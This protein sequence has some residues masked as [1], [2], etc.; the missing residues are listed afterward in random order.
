MQPTARRTRTEISTIASIVGRRPAGCALRRVGTALALLAQ[1]AFLSCG[2]GGGGAGPADP[3]PACG[4]APTFLSIGPVAP[5]GSGSAV[6]SIENGGEGALSET[7]EETC[8]DFT[9][10]P[11]SYEL[12]PGE[13]L[14]VS[15][16]FSP[17]A[18][19]DQ[20]C[21]ISP[22]A[23]C[24][25]VEVLGRVEVP[26]GPACALSTS[27]IDFGA[28]VVGASAEAGFQIRNAGSQPLDAVVAEGCGAFSLEAGG[29]PFSLA[30]DETREVR[31][32][33][34]PQA[35]GGD[36][37]TITLG[38][39]CEN[40]EAAG[41]GV[42]AGDLSGD[43]HFEISYTSSSCGEPVPIV[44]SIVIPDAEH[45]DDRVLR[46]TFCQSIGATDCGP[47]CSSPC[48]RRA[49]ALFDIVGDTFSGGGRDAEGSSDTCSVPFESDVVWQVS[50]AIQGRQISG[51]IAKS[52][53]LSTCRTPG[54][55]PF[56][57]Q[58]SGT[59]TGEIR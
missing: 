29:G 14:D 2:G 43:W 18:E 32:R 55:D 39:L 58:Y 22:G 15:V 8:P 37:C 17:A 36:S 13:S 48:Y 4:V 19:G 50:G 24:A 46:D 44:E 34:S 41:E 47:S 52:I 31:V 51:N 57:C 53:T 49:A 59:F 6:F 20:S 25:A 56:F 9:V 1:T 26:G 11:E 12:P 28:V 33:F 3:G 21:R 7:I 54:A 30:P 5:G 10:E 16:A 42:V 27:T 35:A 23:S 38:P 45:M 40:V